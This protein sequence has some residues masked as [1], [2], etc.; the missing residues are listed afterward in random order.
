MVMIR[1][2]I[3]FKKK[4]DNAMNQAYDKSIGQKGS[5]MELKLG[6]ATIQERKKQGEK[7]KNCF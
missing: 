5:N 1:N 6:A 2:I 4:D 3:T 7:N